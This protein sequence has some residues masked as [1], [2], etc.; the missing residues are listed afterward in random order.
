MRGTQLPGFQGQGAVRMRAA[1]VCGCI[2]MINQ[3]PCTCYVLCGGCCACRLQVS[4]RCDWQPVH[5]RAFC[6]QGGAGAVLEGRGRG[7]D[8]CWCLGGAGWAVGVMGVGQA[9]WLSGYTVPAPSWW[10]SEALAACPP[11][12]RRHATRFSLGS[13]VGTEPYVAAGGLTHP[14][15]LQTHAT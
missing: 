7:V 13:A 15:C 2:A 3:H 1:C 5:G 9:G 4:P 6:A 8:R 14:R 11:R 10:Q 12:A